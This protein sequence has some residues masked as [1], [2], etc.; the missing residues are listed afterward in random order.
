MT[1]CA[2]SISTGTIRRKRPHMTPRYTI[3]GRPRART[4]TRELPRHTTEVHLLGHHGIEPHLGQK[5]KLGGGIPTSHA[6]IYHVRSVLC[7]SIVSLSFWFLLLLS[8]NP[9]IPKIFS[10]FLLVCFFALVCFKRKIQK[11]FALLGLLCFC[12]V[13]FVFVWFFFVC[14]FLKIR[15]HQKYLFFF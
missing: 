8:K 4:R 3:Q 6:Y 2:L 13:C 5:P 10:L 15:K 14:L 7:I 12:L 1:I 11:D 9:K